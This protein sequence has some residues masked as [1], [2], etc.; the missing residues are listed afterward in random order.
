MFDERK[1]TKELLRAR[2]SFKTEVDFFI[3]A[4]VKII[5]PD[6]NLTEEEAENYVRKQIEEYGPLADEIEEELK[7]AFGTSLIIEEVV[8]CVADPRWDEKDPLTVTAVLTV[9][10]WKEFVMPDEIEVVHSIKK[11]RSPRERRTFAEAFI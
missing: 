11:Q 10:A 1:F 4:E 6:E 3:S 8:S 7:E 2:P 5:I 9:Y